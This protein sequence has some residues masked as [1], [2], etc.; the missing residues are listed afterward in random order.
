MLLLHAHPDDESVFTGGTI[1][2]LSAAG[3]TV[4]VA[5]ATLGELGVP[6]DPADPPS[7]QESARLARRRRA[8]LARA[9]RLLGV[10]AHVLLGGAGRWSDSGI[11]ASARPANA[12]AGNTAAATEDAFDVL[13]SVRPHVL[14]SFAD[15]G[16]TGHPDHV[17][18]HEIALRAAARARD[19]R[20]ETIALIARED[21]EDARSVAVDIAPHAARKLRAVECHV[22]QARC[23]SVARALARLRAGGRCARVEDYVVI[24]T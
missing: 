10:D 21:G 13:A 2:R 24:S 6:R 22:S 7:P 3:A 9:C 18:C 23:V 19:G 14:V 16:C 8:E 15:H 11:V 17:A 1:A 12:L 4:V 5:M 20:L